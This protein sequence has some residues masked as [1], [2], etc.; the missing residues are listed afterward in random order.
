MVI[1]ARNMVVTATKP[2]CSHGNSSP[3]PNPVAHK[4]DKVPPTPHCQN[5]KEVR[6]SRV[7]PPAGLAALPLTSVKT[8][9][10]ACQPQPSLHKQCKSQPNRRQQHHP[11]PH[12]HRTYL[13]P[14][15]SFCCTTLI[16]TTIAIATATTAATNFFHFGAKNL[17][18][19]ASD[20]PNSP[21]SHAERD[22][23]DA[24][25]EGRGRRGSFGDGDVG[26]APPPG[27]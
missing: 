2:S 4:G 16:A 18:V 22:V 12:I 14:A 5:D 20:A 25:A 17:P 15:P 19:E 3:K 6:P 24:K 11:T 1:C 13:D 27:V 9:M 26:E 10:S 23:G 21:G 7:F 8:E